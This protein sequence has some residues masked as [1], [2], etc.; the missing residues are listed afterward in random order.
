[1]IPVYQINILKQ[2]R[3]EV[4]HDNRALFLALSHAIDRLENH[5]CPT[6]ENLC[7][8]VSNTN[9]DC[10][11]HFNNMGGESQSEKYGY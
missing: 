7:N 3:D 6:M 4:E 5:K 2:A 11:C 9:K 8:S 10:D 1:M